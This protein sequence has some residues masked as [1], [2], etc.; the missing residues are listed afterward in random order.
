[1]DKHKTTAGTAICGLDIAAIL[2]TAATTATHEVAMF[3]I[4]IANCIATESANVGTLDTVRTGIST[5]SSGSTITTTGSTGIKGVAS[6]AAADPRTAST[7]IHI[8]YECLTLVTSFTIGT[9]REKV[10]HI[11]L[12]CKTRTLSTAIPSARC[13]DV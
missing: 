8:A 6:T 13:V 5:A 11:T 1:M 3:A 9:D 2:M 4:L 10:C 12:T 7:D